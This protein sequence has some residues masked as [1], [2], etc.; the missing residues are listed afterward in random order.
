MHT[1]RHTKYIIQWSSLTAPTPSL[2]D[3]VRTMLRWALPATLSLCQSHGGD[4]PC[5]TVSFAASPASSPKFPSQFP[6][7]R[8]HPSQSSRIPFPMVANWPSCPGDPD[9]LLLLLLHKLQN[10]SSSSSSSSY[11]S[12]YVRHGLLIPRTSIHLP[13][14]ITF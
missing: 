14:P 2:P 6:S 3:S 10:F 11:P 12:A 9:C 5:A 7:E 4:F 1:L 8:S 13:T